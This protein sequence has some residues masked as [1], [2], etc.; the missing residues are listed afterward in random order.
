[1][2]RSKV[3]PV[4]LL[5][6]HFSAFQFRDVHVVEDGWDSLVLDLDGEWPRWAAS[7]AGVRRSLSGFNSIPFSAN[8][9]ATNARL[10]PVYAFGWSLLAA[11]LSFHSWYSAASAASARSASRKA[12]R[13]HSF[14][15]CPLGLEATR[16]QGRMARL[17]RLSS[18]HQQP[19]RASEH[20]FHRRACRFCKKWP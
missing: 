11:W 20:A 7:A 8:T 9:R 10:P 18:A 15:H 2:M 3:D 17:A 4:A 19:K 5:R 13:Q 14:E 6:T 12:S 1:M 16:L